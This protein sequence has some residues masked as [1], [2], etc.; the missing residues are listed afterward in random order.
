MQ[1]EP[2]CKVSRDTLTFKVSEIEPILRGPAMQKEP[3]P[4][5]WVELADGSKM[6]IR[7]ARREEAPIMLDY[8]MEVMQTDYDFYDIVGARV[9]AEILGWYRHRLKD[10]YTLVGMV[11]GEWVGFANGRLM[12]KDINISL[13]TM[14][15][16]RRLRIGAIMYYAKAK[17]AFDVLNN[18]EWWATYESYYGWMRW[19]VGMAQPSHSWP[20]V[21][22]ELGGARVYYVTKDY[23]DTTVAEYLQQLTGVSI[24]SPVPDDLWEKNSGTIR[25][26]ADVNV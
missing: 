7:E 13:H 4:P 10:P 21:Q 24:Q 5:S 2:P 6:V 3:Y 19:G 11:D 16:R 22:H 23:W 25:M 1:L 12:N 17:Y 8:V 15:L 9:Y 26:P 20:D 18:T 14:A